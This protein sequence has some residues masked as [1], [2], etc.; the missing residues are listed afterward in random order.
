MSLRQFG[1]FLLLIASYFGLQGGI[2]QAVAQEIRV[3]VGS[4][5]AIPVTSVDMDAN[6]ETEG[7]DLG[8]QVPMDLGP[9]L[10]LYGAVGFVRSISDNFSLGVRGRAQ[11]ARAPGRI[12]EITSSDVWILLD[13]QEEDCSISNSP[14]GQLRTAT[15]EGRLFLQTIDWIEPYFLVGLGV[16]QTQVEGV[17]ITGSPR[18]IP[19][20]E[21]ADIRLTG[22]GRFAEIQVM[23]A[24]GDVGFG[25]VLPIVGGLSIEPEIRVTGSLP[26]GR[27]SSLTVLTF[28]VGV[29]YGFGQQ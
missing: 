28:S 3:D 14:D 10:N 16:V 27:E 15:I 1:V 24:G 18:E 12:S 17:H 20:E 11:V 4:G 22:Q 19:V 26:G 21:G 13:C 5:W 9:S 23:D 6:I 25:A 8:G 29:S 7:E 2:S